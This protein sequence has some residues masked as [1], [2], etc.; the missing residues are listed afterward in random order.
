M[1]KFNLE[2]AKR[3]EA[4]Q[5]FWN[6]GWRDVHFVGTAKKENFIWV[7]HNGDVI[8]RHID[9]P[10]L[11]MKP[12][13]REMWTFPYMSGGVIHMATPSPIKQYIDGVIADTE[14]VCGEVQSIWM[15]EV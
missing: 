7:E 14:N 8:N 5:W 6:N 4:V 2:A 15:D 9:D 12:K 11:R 13:H 3:G 1:S 10:S